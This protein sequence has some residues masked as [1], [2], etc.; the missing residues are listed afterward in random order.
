MFGDSNLLYWTK[1]KQQLDVAQ[2]REVGDKVLPWNLKRSAPCTPGFLWAKENLPP[3][4]NTDGIEEGASPQGRLW[5]FLGK[6][7]RFTEDRYRGGSWS[8]PQGR[9][10]PIV[11]L[12]RAPTKP[13]VHSRSTKC[14]VYGGGGIW[15]V[16]R[17]E[18]FIP[19]PNFY[20]K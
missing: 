12:P 9:L 2:K 3:G 5:P 14:G 17:E 13:Y 16:W 8:S 1:T 11:G 4:L 10:W 18:H 6:Y 7:G 20:W 15:K 19:I